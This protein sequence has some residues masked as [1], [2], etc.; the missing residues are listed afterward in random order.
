MEVKQRL[1]ALIKSKHKMSIVRNQ[2]ASRAANHARRSEAASSKSGGVAA[3]G[4][5]MII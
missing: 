1:E 2:Q 4:H 5:G 3:A